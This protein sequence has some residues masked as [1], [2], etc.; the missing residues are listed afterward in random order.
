MSCNSFD[1]IYVVFCSSCL[2]EYIGEKD[3]EKT[4]LRDRIVSE[5]TENT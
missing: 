2:E 5:Y 1:V 4:R 3:V